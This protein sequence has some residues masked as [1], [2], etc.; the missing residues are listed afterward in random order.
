MTKPVFTAVH[1][2]TIQAL[3]E[4]GPLTYPRDH[5]T[6]QDLLALD[7]VTEHVNRKLPDVA[8]FRLNARG[9]ESY[10]R[11]KAAGLLDGKLTQS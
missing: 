2:L 4:V 11:A 9:R 1:R 6:M 8:E 3:A 7:L 10:R 5:E